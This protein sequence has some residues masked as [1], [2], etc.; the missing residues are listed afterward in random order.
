MDSNEQISLFSRLL[1]IVIRHTLKKKKEEN[2]I[3]DKQLVYKP[4]SKSKMIS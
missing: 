3:L 2:I 1:E 4:G